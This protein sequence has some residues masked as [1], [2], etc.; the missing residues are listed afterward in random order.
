MY[1]IN[2][3]NNDKYD[4]KN[5]RPVGTGVQIHFAKTQNLF[6][7]FLTGLIGNAAGGFAGG[8][9][10]SLAFAAAAVADALF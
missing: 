7:C 10:G 2:S 5:A 9:A 8:L 3:S 1:H 6:A 4:G